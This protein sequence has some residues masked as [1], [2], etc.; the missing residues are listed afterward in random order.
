MGTQEELPFLPS[1]RL[2]V[3]RRG[4]HEFWTLLF[5]HL[6][7][8]DVASFFLLILLKCLRQEATLTLQLEI[9]N[10]ESIQSISYNRKEASGGSS[11][12]RW[13]PPLPFP[14]PSR[15]GDFLGRNSLE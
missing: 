3:V 15:V 9:E 11:P 5:Q 1:D 2:I 10:P 13:T 12:S 8:T 14:N 7:H 4:P 6:M